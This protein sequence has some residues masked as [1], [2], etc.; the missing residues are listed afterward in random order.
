MASDRNRVSDDQTSP[1]IFAQ[2][3]TIFGIPVDRETIFANHKG[4]YKSRIEKRQRKLIVKTT[5]LN[6]KFFLHDN[7]RIRCLSTGYSPVGTFEQVLTGLAFLLFKRAL[8]IFTDKRLLHIPTRIGGGPAGSIS[9]IFFEDCAKIWLKGRQLMIRYK[10]GDTERFPYIGRKEKKKIK[11]ILENLPIRPK[12]A[13]KLK[14]RVYVCPRCAGNLKSDTSSCPS[15]NLGF[16]RALM[17]SLWAALL[18]GGGYFYNRY[19]AP[20]VL[21]GLAEVIAAAVI[22]YYWMLYFKAEPVNLVPLV[23]SSGALLVEKYIM[24]F[25]AALLTTDFIPVAKDFALQKCKAG[26]PIRS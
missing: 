24:A 11:T 23:C 8:F 22:G 26:T 12:E 20:G 13:G 15:C 6:I 4:V 1:N 7:E 9:Q 5:H 25:H 3:L 19:M 21:I 16:K 18:P 10:T 2:P 17:A 14:G